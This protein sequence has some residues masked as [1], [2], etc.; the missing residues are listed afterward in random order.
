MSQAL[1]RRQFLGAAA[2]VSAVPL[3]LKG[4][5]PQTVLGLAHAGP[6]CPTDI[7]ES[8]EYRVESDALIVRYDMAWR[9]SAGKLEQY[10]MEFR[11]PL[12]AKDVRRFR[13]IAQGLLRD[14][15]PFGA[16]VVRLGAPRNTGK[17]DWWPA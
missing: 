2:A 12:E 16:E 17:P 11:D 14:K 10:R 5:E 4:D 15:K 9:T 3:V 6:L 7:R 1:N 8:L 13:E